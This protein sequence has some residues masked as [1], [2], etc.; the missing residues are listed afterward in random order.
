MNTHGTLPSVIEIEGPVPSRQPP[1]D[2]RLRNATGSW[3]GKKER[4]TFPLPVVG[5]WDAVDY[6]Y[7][8]VVPERPALD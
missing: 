3:Q 2:I 8:V 1:G 7:V 6:C 5:A 4:K